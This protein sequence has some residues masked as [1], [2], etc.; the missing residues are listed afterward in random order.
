MKILVKFPV[1]DRFDKF[2]KTLDVYHKM[3]EDMS[4]M[5]FLIMCDTD[6]RTMNNDAAKARIMSY[7]NTKMLVMD[8]HSKVEAINNGIPEDGYDILLLASDDMIP[9]VKGYD[10]F[11]RQKFMA[12]FPDTDGVTWFNDG[13]QK[14]R[15]NTLCILGRKYY[16]RFGYIYHPSYTSLYADNEF[17]Q[18]SIMLRKV[19]YDDTVIIRHCH[20]SLYDAKDSQNFKDDGFIESDRANFMKRMRKKFDLEL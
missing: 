19:V 14:N 5:E 10:K 17:T 8:N 3:A 12:N 11:I 16:E 18:V 2:F 6:D 15:L 7:P 9:E 20:P 1:R 4:K 13:L